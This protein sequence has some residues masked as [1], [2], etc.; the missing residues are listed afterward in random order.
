MTQNEKLKEAIIKSAV[1]GQITASEAGKRLGI[2]SRQVRK[3]KA[4]M[5]NGQ[6]LK[7]GNCKSSPKRRNDTDRELIV[8]HYND[9]RFNGANFAH[10]QELLESH[11]GIKVSYNS[12]KTILNEAGIKSPKKQRKRKTHTSRE[13]KEHFGELLQ[14]D[15]SCHQWFKP[16]GDNTFYTL[17][18]FIDDATSTVTGCYFSKNECLDG[19]FE[20]FRQTL[21]Q[22]GIPEAIYADGL[23]LFFGKQ[24]DTNIIELLD[25]VSETKT[26]FGLILD[27]LGIDLIHAH[28]PQAKG[29]IE[30][31]WQTF[32]SRLVVEFKVHDIDNTE[33]ANKFLPHFLTRFNK[34]FSQLAK[35]DKTMFLPLPKNINLNLLLCKSTTR[36]L[37]AGLCFSLNGYKFRVNDGLPKATVKVLMSSRIGMKVLYKEQLLTPVPLF[38][39]ERIGDILYFY[40]LKNERMQYGTLDVHRKFSLVNRT[41]N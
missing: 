22:Y 16:L 31:L 21:E 2:S 10:F 34:Q 24:S 14:T 23:S 25:G 39:L 36:K 28:S 35:S 6:S 41:S 40:L 13:P 15:G 17:H 29:K 33:K 38:P 20:A 4:K 19:Y 18:G 12:L 26:Q 30:R 3:L 11:F 37:D 1:D 7:H 8:Q 9:Q 32:Q 5:R 27:S